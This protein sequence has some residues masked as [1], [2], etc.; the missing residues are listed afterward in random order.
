MAA[1][2]FIP[3]NQGKGNFFDG[4]LT[5]D[6]GA[7][8]WLLLL[9]TYTPSALHDTLSD[10]TADECADGD[11]ARKDG[12]SLTATGHPASGTI[13]LD[14]ADIVLTASGT[15]TGKYLA[16]FVGTVAGAAGTDKSVGYVDLD[17][18]GGSVGSVGGSFTVRPHANGLIQVV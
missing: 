4:G 17:T 5:W 9:A 16:A 11:Y 14:L 2:A 7:I 10:V 8:Y 1:G 18:G 15:I 12:A 6:A 13:K 3:Y